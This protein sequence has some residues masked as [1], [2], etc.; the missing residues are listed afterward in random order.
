MHPDVHLDVQF[1]IVLAELSRAGAAILVSAPANG[2]VID[3]G[4]RFAIPCAIEVAETRIE[5]V[6]IRVFGCCFAPPS[7]R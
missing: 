4:L 3:F 7:Y 1:I 5:G 6:A 2:W